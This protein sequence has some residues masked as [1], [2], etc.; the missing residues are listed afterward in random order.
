MEYVTGH[1]PAECLAGCVLDVIMGCHYIMAELGVQV[2]ETRQVTVS[3][4]L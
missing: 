3:V 1:V 4:R 2:F